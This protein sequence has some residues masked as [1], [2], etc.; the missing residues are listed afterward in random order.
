MAIQPLADQ[1][2]VVTGAS[3]GIGRAAALEFSRL[4]AAVV[5]A[6]RRAHAL[7]ELAEECRRLGGRA[8]AVTADVSQEQAVER[9]AAQAIEAYG[10]LDV[11]VNNAAVTILGPFEEMPPE[12]V[13]RVLDTDIQGYLHGARAAIRRFLEQG[14]GIL[15]NVCSQ[16]GLV[17]QPYSVPYTVSQFAVRGLGIGLRQELLDA[18]HIHVCTVFPAAVDTPLFQQAANYSGRRVVPPPPVLSAQRVA[19]AIARLAVHPRREVFV[20]ARGRV[21]NFIRSLSPAL[22]DRRIGRRM[23]HAHFDTQPAPVTPGNLFQPMDEFAQISGGWRPEKLPARRPI[24]VKPLA[25]G[26]AAAGAA[27]LTL[28]GVKNRLT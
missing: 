25:I 18:R 21:E 20:G 2:V 26:T 17:G 5:L 1:V 13:K 27:A 8:T 11:W 16:A 6:A 9:L 3:S 15:I 24:P 19:Q 22:S 7:F 14:R 10:S 23:A 28:W 4:G 12:A